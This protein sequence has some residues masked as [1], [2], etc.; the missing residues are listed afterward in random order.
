MN[1]KQLI[2]LAVLLIIA[3][4]SYFFGNQSNKSEPVKQPLPQ[5]QQND[6]AT[7][8]DTPIAKAPQAQSASATQ[9]ALSMNYD[10]KMYEDKIGQNKHAPV[11][12][13]ML[14]L[15]WSPAF[16]ESQRN[17]NQGDVP[18]RLAYQ[19]AG[20]Q[21]FGWVIHGLWPQNAKARS[22]D[23]HPRYC[24]GDLP[25]VSAKT[26][27]QYLPESPGAALLQG[28]WEKHGSCAFNSAES[29]FAKQ[30]EL[31][32]SL[33]LPAK[34]LRRNDLF[35]WMRKH[36]PQLRGVYLGA[37]KTELYVCYDKKWQPMDC[38]K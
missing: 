11:D 22:V 28:E 15:S 4:I 6:Y 2:K 3:A 35:Q 19:C 27:E 32:Y 29:Y 21:N 9:A 17:K 12:Y 30:K 31:F 25:E 20:G 13:Y 5:Q 1:Q 26:I 14:A 7:E 10:S 38:P 23:Q 18:Q 37:S 16:C 34:N 33:K 36:N 8:N 24:K